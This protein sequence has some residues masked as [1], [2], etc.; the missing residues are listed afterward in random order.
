M[1]LK[2]VEETLDT[3]EPHFHEL[4]TEKDG[5]FVLTGVEGLKTQDD[6]NRVMVSL[7]KERN[8]HKATK[9]KFAPL[10]A[11][12][13]DPTEILTLIDRIP[14]LEELA[15]GKVDDAQIDKIVE[16]RLKAKLTP[17]ERALEAEKQRAELFEKE[18]KTYKERE[19]TTTIHEALRKA[20]LETKIRPDAVDDALMLAER[21]FEVD[22][23]GSVIGKSD[24]K[25]VS[26]GMDPVAWFIENQTKRAYLWGESFG[27]G[28]GGSG[29]NFQS[30]VNP[31]TAENWNLTEQGKILQ[32]NAK[33]A[34][35]LATSAGTT[36]GGK[37]PS[38][39]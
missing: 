37:K 29:N 8:D 5:K 12:G 18:N 30:V 20:A 6:I 28:A 10:V 15:K 17:V 2:L 23:T 36:I 7:T 26:P 14:E 33:R 24:I 38:K 34:E 11:I 35:Q 31:W 16:S 32:A 3:L 4:Y 25:G 27:G 22:E 21:Y 39:K 1:P 13:K 9:E 19:R